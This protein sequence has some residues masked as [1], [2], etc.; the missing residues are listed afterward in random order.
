MGNVADHAGADLLGKPLLLLF[1]DYLQ[2]VGEAIQFA[3]Q[4]VQLLA[5]TGFCTGAP[6]FE[7]CREIHHLTGK[8]EMNSAQ[9]DDFFWRME[10]FETCS[11]R[12][13][14]C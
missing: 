10:I 4:L 1:C 6:F 14:S 5:D 11:I 2:Q 3:S 9:L 8:I 12:P 7:T 13:S